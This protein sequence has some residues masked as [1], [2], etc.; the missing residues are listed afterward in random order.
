MEIGNKLF[1]NLSTPSTH[2]ATPSALSAASGLPSSLPGVL[3]GPG[4]NAVCPSVPEDWETP[5]GVAE[6]VRVGVTDGGVA[7]AGRSAFVSLPASSDGSS[8]VGVVGE[9]ILN[10]VEGMESV[11]VLW[12][13]LG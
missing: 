11:C 6:G 4:G 1:N 3:A 13:G 12:L 8:W 10:S 9:S 5:P 7:A 2:S